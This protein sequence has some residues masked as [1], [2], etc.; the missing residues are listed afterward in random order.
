MNQPH[1]KYE[2]AE[3]AKRAPR[4][5]YKELIERDGGFTLDSHGNVPTDGYMVS[6]PGFTKRYPLETFSD[7]NAESYWATYGSKS[8]G[9][10]FGGWVEDGEVWLDVS[11]NIPTL[12]EAVRTAY[13]HN[14]IAIWDVVN[15]CEIVTGG[16]GS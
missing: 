6:L 9:F 5:N 8:F 16:T 3:Y 4:T 7:Y 12:S 1:T 13:E 11:Q 10:F 2:L 15:K 14:Q